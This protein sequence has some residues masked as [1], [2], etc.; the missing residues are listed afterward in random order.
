MPVKNNNI[1]KYNPGERC[2]RVPF[3]IYSDL[4]YLLENISTCHND[5]NKSSAIKINKHTPS[6]YSLFTHCSFDTTQNSKP[7]CYTGEDC[8]ENFCKTL[9]KLCRKNK[10]LRKKRND[11]LSRR[12]K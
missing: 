1:L 3:I 11:T 9:K 2:I 4:E 12:R 8:I 5:P 10:L 6:G 7:D